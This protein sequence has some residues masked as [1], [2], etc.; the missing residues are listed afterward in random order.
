MNLETE[1]ED[2]D[3]EEKDVE[4]ET[5]SRED[6]DVGEDHKNA[7]GGEDEEGDE[8]ED[9]EE[10][11]QEFARLVDCVGEEDPWAGY[12]TPP[13]RTSGNYL[14]DTAPKAPS[15]WAESPEDLSDKS[16]WEAADSSQDSEGASLW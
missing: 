7:S 1:G 6:V 16:L 8:E 11:V 3:S 13:R 14:R 10:D 9:E 2:E 12:M 5:K 4:G 15:R